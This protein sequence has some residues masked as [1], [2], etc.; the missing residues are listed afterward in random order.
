MKLTLYPRNVHARRGSVGVADQSSCSCAAS[1]PSNTAGSSTSLLSP[2]TPLS[3]NTLNA[4]QSTYGT[5][6][7]PD[8]YK[9][10]FVFNAQTP[11]RATRKRRA[12]H[13][14]ADRPVNVDSDGGRRN[15]ATRLGH[16]SV[17]EGGQ[18]KAADCGEVANKQLK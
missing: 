13:N 14:D 10:A 15:A 3:P 6:D 16:L 9:N 4:V 2:E 7:Y 17:A 18:L 5:E 8:G 11:Q 1:T 12:A